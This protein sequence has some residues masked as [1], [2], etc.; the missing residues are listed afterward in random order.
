[1]YKRQ[2]LL[3]LETSVNLLLFTEYERL[4][5]GEL[6]PTKMVFQLANRLTRLPGG[7]VEDVL[8]RVGEF[9]YPV[10]FVVCET[11]RVANDMMRLPFGDMTLEMNIFNMQR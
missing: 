6:K 2:A 8:I 1:M 3:D 4:E 10:D 11:E 7:V 9:T 5:L